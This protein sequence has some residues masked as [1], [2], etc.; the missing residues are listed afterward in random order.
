MDINHAQAP[1]RPSSFLRGCA[2]YQF[3]SCLVAGCLG[4]G[5]FHVWLVPINV[6]LIPD[7]YFIFISGVNILNKMVG[8]WQCI[9]FCIFLNIFHAFENSLASMCLTHCLHLKVGSIEGRV[10]VHHID[11]S[12]QSKNFT[13][14]CHREG[15][16]V[17][18]V[19]SL[20]F[21]PVRFL[22]PY[23]FVN[24]LW[25]TYDSLFVP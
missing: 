7:I 16:D 4:D 15:N 23:S 25:G 14:K 6:N 13:F 1:S 19:N 21:H 24:H 5:C 22:S 9:L 3:F 10:G 18:S 20:N 11:D 8:S 17:F 12:Q 2:D